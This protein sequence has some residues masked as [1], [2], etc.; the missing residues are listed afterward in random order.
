MAGDRHSRSFF[1]PESGAGW[2]KG[3]PGVSSMALMTPG[4]IR[5]EAIEPPSLH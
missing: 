5:A 2:P 4:A 3:R 1:D